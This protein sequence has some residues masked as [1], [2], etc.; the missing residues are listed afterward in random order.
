MIYFIIY[1]NIKVKK[2]TEAWNNYFGSERKTSWG[3]TVSAPDE[4]TSLPPSR[5]TSWASNASVESVNSDSERMPPPKFG[6]IKK[7]KSKRSAS[8]FGL[9]KS[10]PTTPTER[11]PIKEEDARVLKS[12]DSDSEYGFDSGWGIPRI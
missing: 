8:D 9:G 12:D 7:R 10:A 3:S 6:P 1:L 11:S 4:L 2:T 5:K